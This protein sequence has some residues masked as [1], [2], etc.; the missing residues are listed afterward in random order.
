MKQAQMSD[1]L[2]VLWE[3]DMTTPP[4]PVASA[5][6][7]TD[8]YAFHYFFLQEQ[9]VGECFG[10]IKLSISLA[11]I[12]LVVAT[13]NPLVSFLAT[14]CITDIVISTLGCCA[15]LGWKIGVIEAIIFVMATGLSVDYV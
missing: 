14:L 2:D 10:G 7:V 9:I 6:F 8:V 11:F 1:A 4:P 13:R 15:L 3:V 12:V 5:A